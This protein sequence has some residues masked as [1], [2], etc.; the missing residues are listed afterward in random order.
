METTPTTSTPPATSDVDHGIEAEFTGNIKKWMAAEAIVGGATQRDAARVAGVS[1]NTVSNWKR[2]RDS[3]YMHYLRTH[4]LDT[5]EI[6]HEI[7]SLRA[8]KDARTVLHRIARNEDE[9][10]DVDEQID[11]AKG[12]LTD[13]TNRRR[14]RIEI[15][16]AGGGPMQHHILAEALLL[17]PDVE[18]PPKPEGWDDSYGVDDAS[19]KDVVDADYEVVGDKDTDA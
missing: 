6:D 1:E 5:D 18:K 9:N 16:G 15:T 4:L 11:A 14:T 12:L 8:S 7:H 2:R 19:T 3:E 10:A 13:A 17:A